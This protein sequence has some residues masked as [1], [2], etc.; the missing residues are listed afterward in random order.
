MTRNTVVLIA[1]AA[2][3]LVLVTVAVTVLVVGGDGD[4]GGSA[5]EP[6]GEAGRNPPEPEEPL[7]V[8]GDWVLTIPIDTDSDD[9]EEDDPA[10]LVVELNLERTNEGELVGAGYGEHDG[11][12]YEMEVI[13]PEEVG[14]ETSFELFD[15]EEALQIDIED[16]TESPGELGGHAEGTLGSYE[17]DVEGEFAAERR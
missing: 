2:A 8:T 13:Q 15:G 10:E 14:G 11:E 12:V 3:L 4:G 5:G 9:Y 6:G 16:E 7:D 1:G 17:A